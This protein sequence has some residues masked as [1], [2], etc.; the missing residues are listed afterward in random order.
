[1]ANNEK[2]HCGSGLKRRYCCDKPK[3][4]PV[5]VNVATDETVTAVVTRNL[6]SNRNCSPH[7]GQKLLG[8]FG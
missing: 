3:R 7:P 4:V 6:L 1:M 2:C 5:R 8:S